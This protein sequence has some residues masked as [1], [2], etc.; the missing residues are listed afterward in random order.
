MRKG[1]GGHLGC[2][3]RRGRRVARP[4][5]DEGGS[6]PR[7]DE[8]GSRRF[9]EDGIGFIE[10]LVAFL[11][12][13]IAF[14]P[15]LEFLPAGSRLIVNSN[16]QRD[17]TELANTLLSNAQ[18]SM[19]PP[20]YD[21]TVQTTATWASV[22]AACIDR[23]DTA[24][25]SSASSTITDASVTSSDVGALVAG[26]NIPSPTYVGTVTA[27]S[28]A[29]FILSASPD[30]TVP[31]VPTGS[32]TAVSLSRQ[33][34]CASTTTQNGATFHV[35]TLGGWCALDPATGQWTGTVPSTGQASYHVL[36]K[37]AWGKGASA[38]SVTNVVVD[39]TELSVTAGAPIAG[40]S[41]AA[42]PLGAQ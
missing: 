24:T 36:T 33:V 40:E 42:C 9:D 11:V 4:R 28:P 8:G 41:V 21:P 16:H 22:T 14:L 34:N 1:T 18:S 35:Y 17:A 30:T 7:T 5:S 6:R 37:V 27:G 29:T 15:I 26:A 3:A 12:F 39:G 10:I 31:V 32:G 25:Y 23:T 13:M 38:T 20:A 2:D 19:I